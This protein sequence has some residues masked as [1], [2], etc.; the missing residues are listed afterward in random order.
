MRK[1]SGVVTMKIKRQRAPEKFQVEKKSQEKAKIEH[2]I[3]QRCY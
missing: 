3:A 2:K 1:K